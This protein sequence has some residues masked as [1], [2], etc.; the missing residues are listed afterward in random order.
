MNVLLLGAILIVVLAT[1]M[2]LKLMYD[3]YKKESYCTCENPHF[4][5][6]TKGKWVCSECG[7]T[8]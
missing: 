5:K 6:N 1:L 3:F 8:V 2:L 4:V 7:K